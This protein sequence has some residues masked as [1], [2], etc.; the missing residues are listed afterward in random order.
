MAVIRCPAVLAVLCVVGLPGLQAQEPTPSAPVACATQKYRQFD[1]WVGDWEVRDPNGNVLGTNS[2]TKI[3]GGCVLQE[4]WRGATGG[5]G[6]SF[7]IY[8]FTRDK[9]HQTWVSGSTLLVLE[10]A[11]RDGKMVLEGLTTGQNGSTVHNRITWTP[12]SHDVVTQV[13]DTSPH[14]TT[15]TTI[16][17]G[18]Y[19]RENPLKP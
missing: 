6:R 1:F 5:T 9:W 10:G 16:F 17:N 15:W 13:W 11:L 18:R 14:G 7:S 3:E 12:V 4:M 2:I 19:T 8:D